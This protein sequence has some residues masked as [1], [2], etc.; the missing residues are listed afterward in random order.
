M[1][2]AEKA[3]NE[4][5]KNRKNL[6]WTAFV[7]A[8]EK[9]DMARAEKLEKLVFV[10]A[11]NTERGARVKQ[12][13]ELFSRGYIAL[14]KGNPDEAI[15]NFQATIRRKP[16][17]WNIEPLEDCLGNA[18]LKLGKYD[19]A[20]AEYRRILQLNPNYPLTQFYLAQALQYK[21]LNQEARTAY[22]NFLQIWQNADADIPEVILAKRLLE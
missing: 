16:P 13:F 2:S 11:T 20:I 3:V 21:G 4:V 5:L 12:R 10:K 18:F 22:Q 1:V 8:S 7:V 19:E 17:I 15:A 14:Q 6:V 9:G